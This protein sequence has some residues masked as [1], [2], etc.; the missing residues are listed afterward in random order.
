MEFT[1]LKLCNGTYA[2]EVS[3]WSL[4]HRHYLMEL[5]LWKL[6]SGRYHGSYLMDLTQWKLPHGTYIIDIT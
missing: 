4:H 5:T 6:P 2:M 3:S 1:L